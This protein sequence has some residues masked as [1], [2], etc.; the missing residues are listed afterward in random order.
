MP[1]WLSYLIYQRIAQH[2]SERIDPAAES[3]CVPSLIIFVFAYI[4]K[5]LQPLNKALMR[6]IEYVTESVKEYLS[7]GDKKALQN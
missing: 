1:A 4:L 6:V 7:P 2:T 5:N 3:F